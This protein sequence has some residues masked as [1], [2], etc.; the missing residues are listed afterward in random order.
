VRRLL[1]LI[2]VLAA[3]LVGVP[4]AFL[5]L[6][7]EGES[8]APRPSGLREVARPAS[9]PA[10]SV[11]LARPSRE[12]AVA[13]AVRPGRPLQLTATILGQS[14]KG[15]DG[16]D[17]ELIAI[18]GSHGAS[19]AAERCGP[20]CYAT[21]L[22]LAAPERFAVNI[23]GAGQFRSVAF[24]LEARWPPPPGG[25][26]LSRASKAFRALRTAVFTEHLASGPGHG[27]FTTWKLKAPNRLEYEIRGGAGGI[28]I[29]GTR[30]D[31]RAPG[32]PWVRSTTRVLPQPFVPW[33]SRV[34]NARVLHRTARRITVSWVD[35]E[36]PS[37]FTATFD[38]R[39]AL[40][41]GLRMT[42]AAHFM[43]HRY[44]AF[45]RKVRIEPPP[46]AGD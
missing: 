30:W 35:P 25:A 2:V 15:V 20:G 16:L 41:V 43:R 23:S 18:A 42:A 40:P 37:W 44:L 9:P 31:R 13:L 12:L 33:G 3:L 28:V 19:N 22:P 10:G 34:A 38:R 14:G 4:A 26:F 24:P 1:A 27:I 6:R 8:A 7:S 32:A 45:D 5:A 21:T 36:V 46:S 39:T 17:V 11:V 29:G